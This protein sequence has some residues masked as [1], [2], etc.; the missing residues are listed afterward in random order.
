MVAAFRSVIAVV[1]AN[2]YRAEALALS[3]SAHSE[4]DTFPL[5]QAESSALGGF[6]TVLIDM[7]VTLDSALRL[8]LTMTTQCPNATVVVLG[9]VESEESIV[10]LAEA[11]ASG[12]VPANASFQEMLSIIQSARK[13]EFAC[14]PDVTYVLFSRLAELARNQEMTFLQASGLTTREQQVMKLLAQ[15]LSNEEIAERLCVSE[16]TVKNH[17]H[18]VLRKLHARNR[19]VAAR[20][21]SSFFAYKDDTHGFELHLD[22]AP[23]SSNREDALIVRRAI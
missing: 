7:D 16:Y 18:H 23:R 12:Y 15:D 10:R 19:S 9:V 21:A 2:R 20:I 5:T 17:V 22:T 4:H 3:I 6:S 1:A 13:G 14:P 11:G 8:I